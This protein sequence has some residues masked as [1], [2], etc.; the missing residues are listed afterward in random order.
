MMDQLGLFNQQNS[1]KVNKGSMVQPLEVV[2]LPKNQNIGELYSVPPKA[3]F[4]FTN[5]YR[6]TNNYL[7]HVINSIVR[8][9]QD[10]SDVSMNAIADHVSIPK[11]RLKSVINFLRKSVII[12][13][14]YNLTQFG[15]IIQNT[16]PFF[17]DKGLLWFLHYLISSNANL[18][19]WSRLFSKVLI[20]GIEAYPREFIKSFLDVKGKMSEKNFLHNG[21]SEITATLTSYT[22]GLFKPLNLV[23]R[24]DHGTY[25]FIQDDY[26]IQELILL[27]TIFVFRDRY[28]PGV[29]TLEIPQIIMHDYSPGLI[30]RLKEFRI[31][32][33]LDQLHKLNLITVETRLGL[34][35]IRFKDDF[36]WLD[37]VNIHFEGLK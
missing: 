23:T 8:I 21:S 29:A 19:I 24:T 26:Y 9:R 18:V 1:K 36:S 12:D 25:T 27:A 20:H 11:E 14:N 15:H 10:S 28:F 22:E 16:D 13:E 33:G 37:A 17:L 30:F 4:R 31:R 3:Q 2:E 32:E 7:G 6:I 5:N 34:D 35:Q